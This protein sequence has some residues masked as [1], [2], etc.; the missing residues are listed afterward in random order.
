MIWRTSVITLRTIVLLLVLPPHAGAQWTSIGELRQPTRT[1]AGLLY[2]GGTVAVSVTS[3]TPEIIRVRLVP[4]RDF[5]RDH[6]YAVPPQPAP[7]G[8]VT[9]QAGRAQSIIDTTA[10]RVIVRQQPFQVQIL[11]RDGAS[12]DEDAPTYG[13]AFAATT[14]RTWKRLR[15]DEYVYG[16]GE[17][18]GRLNKRGRKL[19]GYSYVMWNSDTYAYDGSTD[20]I[21]VTVPFYMVLRQGRAHGIFLDNTFRSSFDVGHTTP[22]VLSFGVEGGELNYY[23]IDGPTPKDVIRR[24]TD[25]TGRMPL[26]ALWTLGYHQCRYSYYPDSQVRFIARNFRER[27]IPADTIWLDIHYQDGYKPFTWDPE[28]FPDPGGLIRD[29]RSAGFRVVTIVDPHPKKERGYAPYDAGLA[30]HH[31][32]T[33]LDGSVYEAPV[34]PA[35]AERHP[36]PSVF[37]DFTR[38]ATRD[39]WGTLFKPFVDL[40]VAG[41]WNDMDEPAVFVDPLGTFPM[42]VRHDNEGQPTDHSEIHNVYGQLTSRATYE[43]LRRLRPNERAF[44]LTRATYAGG[45]RYAAVWPGDNISTWSALVDGIP[46]LEGLGLSGFPF[47]GT[48]IG[49]FAGAATA[50]LYTRWLQAAVFSPFMRSHTTYGTPPQDPWSYGTDYEAVN[51]RAIELRYELLPEI[52]NIMREASVSGLPALRPMFLEFPTDPRTYELDTQFMFGDSLLVAPIVE[53][54][55]HQRSLYLPAGTWFDFWTGQRYEGGRDL[56]IGVSLS[57]I[58]IFVRGG[59][60]VFRQPVVQH[61]GEIT[62]Q[63][64]LDVWLYPGSPAHGELYEDDG[65]SMEYTR[66]TF[67]LR[68]VEWAGTAEDG[69]LTIRQ[70]HNGPGVPVRN[71]MLVHVRG[72]RGPGFVRI[73]TGDLMKLDAPLWGNGG[74][75]WRYGDGF[76]DI[77]LPAGTTT[78]ELTW[79]R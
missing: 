15:D 61:T 33:N 66:G 26:P 27:H 11:T 58:P 3:V 47:V 13:T 34:W 69:R 50:E 48:D 78:T 35:N 76:L 56:T 2:R 10:L 39:W 21:Y 8:P 16:F 57:S 68:E 63:T 52:Y 18:N 30:G 6:S 17:K 24:Y 70:T 38:P 20:P 28:R 71:R 51:R 46:T 19:G 29:L 7:S 62:E 36:G 4:G 74:P 59:H 43:G 72:D 1:A 41:I 75:G 64:P 14:I 40:G 53:D 44:V 31:F 49:G 5:G 45:Q 42:T 67:S 65:I 23:F 73:G 55:A 77:R 12:L 25:L 32:V 79:G 60:V 37:P 22:G 9:V 54:N